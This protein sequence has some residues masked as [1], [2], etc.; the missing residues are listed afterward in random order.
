MRG[1][2][3]GRFNYGAPLRPRRNQ[4]PQGASTP[5]LR[6]CPSQLP[7]RKPQGWRPRRDSSL[8]G[9]FVDDR[10][11][12]REVVCI[13]QRVGT[14]VWKASRITAQSMTSIGDCAS[15]QCSRQNRGD[16]AVL[17]Q[18]IRNHWFIANFMVAISVAMTGWAWFLSW[19]T[20]ELLDSIF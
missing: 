7:R 13:D 20:V 9:S 2:V 17:S 1:Q 12:F 6:T 18:N 10:K 14:S 11:L 4:C 8:P 15:R 5:C 16:M 19:L 3:G